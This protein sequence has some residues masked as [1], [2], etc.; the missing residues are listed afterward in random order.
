[1]CKVRALNIAICHL[2]PRIEGLGRI[3]LGLKKNHTSPY[4]TSSFQEQPMGIDEFLETI[5]G[6]WSILYFKGAR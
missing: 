4:S 1:L 2:L 3:K 6:S 5:N